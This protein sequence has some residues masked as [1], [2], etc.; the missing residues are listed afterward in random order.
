MSNDTELGDQQEAIMESL[1]DMG[2]NMP[3]I[4]LSAPSTLAIGDA[5]RMIAELRTHTSPVVIVKGEWTKMPNWDQLLIG[6]GNE[7]GGASV[8]VFKQFDVP[9]LNSTYEYPEKPR[10]FRDKKY[11]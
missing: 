2:H 9:N 5:F 7:L 8:E 1:L 10:S 3:M 11:F 4:C 6:L